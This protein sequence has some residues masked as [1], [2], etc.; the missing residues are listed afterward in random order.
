MCIGSAGEPYGLVARYIIAEV[1]D[2]ISD[3]QS[4]CHYALIALASSSSYKTPCNPATR[5]IERCGPS[6]GE[7]RAFNR[8]AVYVMYV[9]LPE[10]ARVAPSQMTWMRPVVYNI[11]Q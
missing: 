2:G 3:R 8:Y 6:V 1:L 9:M 4:W 10:F 5:L 11:T 7:P